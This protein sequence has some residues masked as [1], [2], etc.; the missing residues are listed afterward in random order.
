MIQKKKITDEMF[1][2]GN[3]LISGFIESDHYGNLDKEKY[4]CVNHPSVL[5]YDRSCKT[6]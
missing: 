2:E 3:K 1:I 6:C 4:F 5:Y